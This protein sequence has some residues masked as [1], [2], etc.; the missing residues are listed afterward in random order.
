MDRFEL[1]A[2]PALL[3]LVACGASFAERRTPA[4]DFCTDMPVV[5]VGQVPDRPYHRL[6][7]IRSEPM[8]QTEAERLESLRK[9]ACKAGA[10][11]VIEAANEEVRGENG[12]S[13]STVSSGTAVVWSGSSGGALKLVVA[14]EAPAPSP[15]PPPAPPPAVSAPPAPPLSNADL[16]MVHLAAT[17]RDERRHVDR[18]RPLLVVEIQGLE[19]LFSSTPKDAADRPRLMRRIAEAYVDLEHV[20]IREGTDKVRD[21]ARTNAL[22]YYTMLRDQYPKWCLMGGPDPSKGTGCADEVLY[23]LAYEHE[24]GGVSDEARKVYLSLVQGWPQSRYIPGAYLAFG[25]LFFEEA[26][27]DP[28]KYPLA[29]QAYVQVLKYPPPDNKLAGFAR[30][31]LAQVYFKRGDDARAI[32]ELKKVI[33]FARQFSMLPGSTELAEAAARDATPGP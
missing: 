26:K 22:R 15:P 17:V 14:P 9:E 13:M 18:P 23:Y 29:E 7:P 31:R 25:E 32:A 11:A 33:E 16:A 1:A 2:I 6:R 8:A 3:L 30:Y 10:D 24:R 12:Q 21:A 4:G 20:A 19:S 27:S 5:P 28:S